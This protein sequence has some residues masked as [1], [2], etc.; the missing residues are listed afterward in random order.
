MSYFF[1]SE[2]HVISISFKYHIFIKPFLTKKK[3]ISLIAYLLI[4]DIRII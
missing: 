2:M 4:N 1:I 3:F